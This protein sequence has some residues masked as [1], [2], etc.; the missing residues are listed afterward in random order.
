MLSHLADFQEFFGPLRL[1]RYLTFRAALGSASA[2]LI[3]LV[4]APWL[5]A[6]LRAFK[7]AQVI[8]TTPEMGIL[9]ASHGAKQG[10]PT[11]GGFIIYVAVAGSTLLWADLNL[12]VITALFVYTGLTV[13]GFLDDYLK[14]TKKNTKGLPGRFKLIGQG[15]VTVGAV[16]LLYFVDPEVHGEM[17]EVWVPFLKGPLTVAAPVMLLAPF[18]FLV[19]AGS[20]NAI[21]LTDGLDGLAIGCTVTVALTYGIFAY[22]AGNTI[23]ANYLFISYVPGVG[24]LA[25]PCAAM[26]GAGLA[27][28]WYNCHPANVFMG[29]TGSLALGGLIGVIAF[30]VHQPL[31]L[32]IVGGIFVWE[33]ASVMIQV[34][35][36][37]Y[38]GRRVFRM[39]PIHHHF[40]KAGWKETQVVI[41]FWILSL[42]FAIAGLATLKLR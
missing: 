32:V 28:L 38:T 29:D 16:G 11:M 5:I 31:T 2:L 24:E 10:T 21:N 15:L 12:Y 13:V 14:V 39:A 23:V 34:T 8:R 40:E 22:A 25:I 1:F 18:L 26:V 19:L 42:C 7:V 17:S 4:V 33:A 27:F 41:R 6:H 36:F 35:S 20:S 9:A 37:K 3:G 30:M